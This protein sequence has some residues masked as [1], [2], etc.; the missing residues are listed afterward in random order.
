[1]RRDGVLEEKRA[2]AAAGLEDVV[3]AVSE[4]KK[5]PSW[6]EYMREVGYFSCGFGRLRKGKD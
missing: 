2:A 4:E 6:G 5:D 3:M 1:M